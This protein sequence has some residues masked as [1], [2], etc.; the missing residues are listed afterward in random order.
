MA[1]AD[2]QIRQLAQQATDRLQFWQSFVNADRIRRMAE[3]GV[4]RGDFAAHMLAH[5][6]ALRRYYMVDSWRHL[7]DW[8][9]PWNVDDDSFERYYEETLQR[10]AAHAKK[11]VVLRGTTKEVIG[12][13]RDRSLDFAYIDGDHTLRGITID[14]ARVYPKVRWGGWIGGDDLS[15]SIFQHSDDFEPTLV[16]PYALYFAEAMGANIYALP[17]QQFLIHKTRGDDHAL[18]DLD[19]RYGDTTLRAQLQEH[20]APQPTAGDSDGGG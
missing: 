8:D 12:K 16:F 15:P 5:C 7:D 11:R 9:K 10:T 1:I 20:F 17:H 13:V 2:A 18:M 3:V 6:P 14:L 19:G 4:Y